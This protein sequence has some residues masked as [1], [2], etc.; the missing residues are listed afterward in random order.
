[1]KFCIMLPYISIIKREEW[2]GGREDLSMMR[3]M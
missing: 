3:Y 1:M 2:G